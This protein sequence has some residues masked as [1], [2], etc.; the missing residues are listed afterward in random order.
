MFVRDAAQ[1][2]HPDCFEEESRKVDLCD[3]NDIE[4]SPLQYEIFVYYV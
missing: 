2:L 4:N 3:G 1:A